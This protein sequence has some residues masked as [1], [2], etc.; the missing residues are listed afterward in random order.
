MLFSLY[1]LYIYYIYYIILCLT[2]FTFNITV[3]HL[4]YLNE[5]LMIDWLMDGLVQC[6]V[7]LVTPS[8]WEL[9]SAG[10]CRYRN[11]FYLP[12]E[13]CAVKPTLTTGMKCHGCHLLVP[14]GQSVPHF[15][16]PSS[17][18]LW[19]DSFTANGLTWN[20][21]L[22]TTTMALTLQARVA[23]QDCVTSP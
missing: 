17:F 15:S 22:C 7:E 8:M 13:C 5:K 23:L 6:K 18:S 1:L 14:L 3:S 21:Q 20:W 2:L 16:H 10:G 19:I 12:F 9:P 11:H 4:L